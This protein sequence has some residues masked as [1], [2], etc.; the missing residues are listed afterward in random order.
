M[1]GYMTIGEVARVKQVSIKALRYYEK[2]G[3][4]ILRPGYGI[5]LLQK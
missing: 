3:I 1:D 5:P 4:G 2:I